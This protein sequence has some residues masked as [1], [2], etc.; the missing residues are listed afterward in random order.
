M[1]CEHDG[2]MVSDKCVG[3][4]DGGCV[5]GNDDIETKLV[6]IGLLSGG[7]D[8]D[9]ASSGSDTSV[10]PL[11]S[12]VC[13]KEMEEGKEEQGTMEGA[14]VGKGDITSVSSSPSCLSSLSPFPSSPAPF[15]VMGKPPIPL[16]PSDAKYVVN[17]S[18]SLH[19]RCVTA[20]NA[21]R[22]C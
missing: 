9:I 5:G 7:G 15:M 12:R 10:A 11:I 8:G 22:C 18:L 13:E 21:S 19:T 3:C 2:V 1:G 16:H 4:C 20:R 14:L 17:A 6:C